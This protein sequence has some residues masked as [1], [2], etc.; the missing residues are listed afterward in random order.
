LSRSIARRKKPR[1]AVEDEQHECFYMG[2]PDFFDTGIF[3]MMDEFKVKTLGTTIKNALAWVV[4]YAGCLFIIWA[5]VYV[6][7]LPPPWFK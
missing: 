7:G 3:L 5:T 2:D 6:R 4:I 1:F